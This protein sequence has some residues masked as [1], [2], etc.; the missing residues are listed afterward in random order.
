MELNEPM[1]YT[2][3][4]AAL[5]C[6]PGAAALIDLPLDD[7]LVVRVWDAL[8]QRPELTDAL[9][10]LTRPGLMAVKSFALASWSG[11]GCRVVVRGDVS[12]E[13]PAGVVLPSDMWGESICAQPGPIRLAVGEPV[14]PWLVLVNGIVGASAVRMASDAE[15]PAEEA[16]VAEQVGAQ[17]AE[18]QQAEAQQAQ[19]PAAQS[20]L[21]WKAI[22]SSWAESVPAAVAAPTPEPVRVPE[23]EPEP[24]QPVVPSPAVT[25]P[26]AGGVL[27]ESFPWGSGS[28]EPAVSEPEPAPVFAPAPAAAF[29]PAAA[30][31]FAPEPAPVSPPAPVSAPAAMEST[32]PDPE[33]LEMTIDRRNMA[34]HSGRPE[35]M[36]VAAR[37]PSG[38]LTP[39]YA[40]RCRVCG[41]TLPP[42]QPFEVARPPLGV[43]RLSNGDKV[44]LDRGVIMGRNP[45][46]P[47]GYTGDQPNLIKLSDPEKDISSQHL[48]VS[49]DFWHVLVIDL[50]STNGTEV[51][52]P[53]QPPVRLTP[54]DPMTIEPGT[55]VILAGVQDFVFEVTG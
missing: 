53:G 27:I 52:L 44:L 9:E 31:V 30:P 46:L 48:E 7:P 28:S 16:P 51:I 38:H 17:Q 12:A 42:Q 47:P 15:V 41:Q 43:L 54:H 10:V 34:G 55:R 39:A 1:V 36:V 5:V 40:G 50:G 33:V 37:C 35:T 25:P 26:P 11:Q 18:V 2:P 19:H 3:G 4:R 13:G 20:E 14:G 45:H 22:E 49:L 24:V 21:S 6:V 8:R 29:M 23:P 32:E